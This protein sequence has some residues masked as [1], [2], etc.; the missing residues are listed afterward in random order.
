MA[1][2]TRVKDLKFFYR[3]AQK[4]FNGLRTS[5]RTNVFTSRQNRYGSR[6]ILLD[7]YYAYWN[8]IIA[9]GLGGFNILDPLAYSPPPLYILDGIH[10]S[11]GRDEDIPESQ[12]T[13]KEKR[14][15]EGG[16]EY[17]GRMLAFSMMETEVP[18]EYLVFL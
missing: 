12:T 1:Y 15:I 8:N 9:R 2:A 6:I 13:P 7:T 3:N 16:L 5:Y 10:F 14:H 17:W 18:M 11:G 4:L